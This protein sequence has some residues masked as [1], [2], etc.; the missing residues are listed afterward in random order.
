MSATSPSKL[1]VR[2]RLGKYRIERRLGEGGF[3]VVYQAMDTIM[4]ARVALK[5][6]HGSLVDDALLSSFRR[7]ARLIS[8]LDHEGILQI[9]DASV[10]DDRLVISFPLGNETLCDRLSRRM[11]F[12]TILSF[13]NQLLGAVAQAHDRRVI[14]CDI[15][16]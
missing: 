1:R 8:R 3:A 13:C 16:P 2:Q 6:P 15:K 4:G 5:V 7:E 14:H 11:S 10:I 12:E 9:K